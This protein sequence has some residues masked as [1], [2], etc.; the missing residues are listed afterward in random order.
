[1]NVGLNAESEINTKKTENLGTEG[2]YIC[3]IISL[4]SYKAY[5]SF[6]HYLT[7]DPIIIIKACRL[8]NVRI[9]T[10]HKSF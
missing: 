10:E 2:Y 4:C 5:I 6:T 7:S 8:M 1:M 3:G 9:R